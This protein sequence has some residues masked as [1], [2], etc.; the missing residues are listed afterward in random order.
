[1]ATTP[2]NNNRVTELDFFSIKNQLRTYLSTQDRFKDFNFEGSNMSVL[3]D[4]LAYNTYQNNFYTQMAISEM[5]LDSAQLENSVMSHA[6]ELNY[7]P[8]SVKS[9]AALVDVLIRFSSEEAASAFGSSI[10]VPARTQFR[11]SVNRD[12][13]TFVTRKACTASRDALDPTLFRSRCVELFE[14]SYVEESFFL[15]SE[16]KTCVL[17]NE[18]VDTDSILVSVQLDD[19]TF[20]EFVYRKDIYGVGANDRV[21]YLQPDY[22]SRYAVIFGED[23]FGYQPRSNQQIRI[24]YQVSRGSAS[25][26]ATNFTSVSSSVYA[27]GADVA[28]TVRTRSADGQERESLSDIKFFAPRSIQI[29]ERAVTETDYEVLLKQR[30]NVKDVAVYGGDQL[31]PPRYG[32]VAISA[33]VDGG[34]SEGAK[35][36]YLAYLK[37]KTP[38]AIQPIFV[39]P[40]FLYASLE[41]DVFYD[42]KVLSTSTADLRSKIIQVLQNYNTSSL[43]KFGSVLR[44]SRLASLIDAVD[45]SILN[46]SIVA[47]P[48]VEYTPTVGIKDTPLFKFGS[49]FV[50]P[51]AF[52]P[53]NGFKDYKPSIRSSR[54]NYEGVDAFLQ[55][56]G[57]GTIQIINAD[58]VTVEILK[59]SIGTVDYTKGDV[60]LVDFVTQGYSNAINI[61]ANTVNKDIVAPKQRVLQLR[62]QD[63][64]IRFT[65]SEVS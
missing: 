5:F 29:Q 23:K 26:G 10:T 37:D 60:R 28:V 63:V 15:D 48:F 2:P 56:N 1:M 57:R 33:N 24:R 58:L 65:Q 20:T 46:T 14:G 51:Y 50:V 19:F 61:F 35:S 52:Q 31:D 59:Q 25:N 34:V 38:L 64:T 13:F 18:N 44:V 9:S 39:D 7:L 42:F 45:V 22:D 16:T 32:K 12:S 62:E 27:P 30:F 43:D 21:F 8:R 36:Q 53:L 17:S 47:R 40:E 49:S 3:L 55:D 54:F 4:V 11:S 6:K 41:I